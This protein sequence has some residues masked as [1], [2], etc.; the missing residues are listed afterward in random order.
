MWLLYFVYAFQRSII[1]SL[2]PYI[3]SS[4]DQH[5]LIP[6]VSLVSNI[7]SGVL[8]LPVAKMLDHWGRAE[9]L[10]VMALTAT[11]GMVLM[12]ACSNIQTYCIAQVRRPI[13]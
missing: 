13:F 10:I 1:N 2:T 9:S 3:V 7:M 12:A 4:F 5:S 8:Y 6:V 11:L